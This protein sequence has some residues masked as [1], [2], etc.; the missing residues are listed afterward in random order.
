MT[1]P[2]DTQGYRKRLWQ[3]TT[4]EFMEKLWSD[5]AESEMRRLFGKLDARKSFTLNEK[6]LLIR[7]MA[8]HSFAVKSS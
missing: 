4:R 3:L 2:V 7:F 5:Q 6:K 1:I 8:I